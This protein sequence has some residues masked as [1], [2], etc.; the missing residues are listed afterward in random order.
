MNV[1]FD[2]HELPPPSRLPDRPALPDPFEAFDG[3]R[4]ETA[5]DWR[6]RRAEILQLF[7]HYVYGYAPEPPAIETETERTRG[8][9]DGAAALVEATIR[10]AGLPDDAPAISMACFLPATDSDGG[11]NADADGGGVDDGNA[12]S[13]SGVPTVLALNRGGNHG[14][15]DDPAVTVTDV[16][17]RHGVDRRGVAED[18]WCVERILDRGYGF[19]TYQFADL[20]PDED[21]FSTGIFPYLDDLPGPPGTE[22]GA[23]AAWAWGLQRCVDAL[24]G[25][26]GADGIDGEGSD[27]AGDGNG[28]AGVDGDR[29]LVTGHS[30]RGKA[31]LLAGATDERI[32]LVAPHQSGTGGVTLS[33]EN[34][35]ETVDAITGGF[36]H[37]FDDHFAAFGGRPERLPVDQHLLVA[38]V[39]PRPL[40][41]TEGSRDEWTNPDRALDSLRAAE[42]VWD[43]LDGEGMVGD[44]LLSGD[45]AVTAE[46]AGD[47]L[48]YRR[49]TEHTLNRGYWDAILDFA[50]VHLR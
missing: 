43:L 27:H 36:P 46:S 31:A 34:D 21:D 16:A 7:R 9:L 11:G 20:A 23:I 47:L 40:I 2:P 33:R 44:G 38:C 14:T 6:E 22:W 26:R 39:A 18:Y 15:V 41:D 8:V 10:F 30:R 4:V 49:K 37:W 45:D 3:E 32:A 1:P 50:D 17:E 5:A 25:E 13:D 42:P 24:R 28:H 29:I 12:D 35:Q 48:Q 19:A